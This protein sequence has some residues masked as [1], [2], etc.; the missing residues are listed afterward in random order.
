MKKHLLLFILFICSIT[1]AQ[2]KATIIAAN[3]N[4]PIPYVNI[5][6]E[7]EN[8]GATSDAN[9]LFEI[10]ADTTDK[11]IVF[12]ALGYETLTIP[13]NEIKDNVILI[14]SAEELDEVLLIKRKNEHTLTVG[15]FN[16]KKVNFY[17]SCGTTPWITARYFPY[18]DEYSKTSF[19]QKLEF[20][21]TTHFEPKKGKVNIRLYEVDEN[22][23]SWRL[24]L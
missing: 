4:T 10:T 8:I 13:A 2:I 17:F 14:N 3:D 6:I 16:K 12:S 19:L 21:T 5:W 11:N 24:Y 15:E 20:I 18:K 9:G 23:L 7:N 22:G 1:N